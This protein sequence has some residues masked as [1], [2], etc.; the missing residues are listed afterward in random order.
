MNITISKSDATIEAKFAGPITEAD[1]ETLR[2]AFETMS[3]VGAKLV[4]LDLS[5]VPVISSTNIG[6]LIVFYKRLKSQRRD[7]VIEGIH[8]NLY[9]LFTSI[10]LDKMLTI[11]RNPG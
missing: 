10:N 2:N 11:V 1:G 5:L 3:A 4:K 8:D 7:L 6:K 9:E